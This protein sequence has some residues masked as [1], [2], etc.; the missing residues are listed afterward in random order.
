MYR[1]ILV[2]GLAFFIIHGLAAQ[3]GTIGGTVQD[4]QNK[5]PL[6]NA[7]ANLKSI[8][9]SSFSRSVVTDSLGRFRFSDLQ[10]DSFLLTVSFVGYNP[11]TRGMRLDSA[12]V[13]IEI[14]LVPNSS[15]ELA[16]VI[17][18]STTAPVQKGDTLQ[19]SA[20]QFKV[21]PDATSEDLVRKVPGI[22]VENGEVKAQGETVRRVTLDG[23]ELF[24]DDATAALRNLPAEVV[25]KIQVLDRLS[26]QDRASGVVTGD[27]Q[28][29]INI[30]T[31]AGMRNG[32][33]GRVFGGYGTDDRYSIGG[34]ATFLKENRRIALV[35]QSNNI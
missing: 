2:L 3:S 33:Y 21:N 18:R 8:A 4:Q 7:T 11:V 16:T 28:K 22:T 17:I 23:R 15:Q 30:V 31:K 26:D 5:A 35:G 14:N 27:T 19:I 25:D 20:S 32:Q 13:S 29:E 9:D 12:D 24:G 34:N 10:R 6:S 1:R